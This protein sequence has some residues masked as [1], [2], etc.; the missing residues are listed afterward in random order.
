MTQHDQHNALEDRRA[1][2]RRTPSAHDLD[3]LSRQLGRPVRDVVEIGA[4]CVCGNPLVATTAPRLSNGIPFPTTYY[5]T[6]PVLTAAV[7][8][9]EAD[10]VMTAMSDRLTTDPELAGRYRAAHL[11]YLAAREA[12]GERAGTG[13]VPEIDGVSAGGMPTRVKCL[14]VLVGHALAAGPGVNPLGDEAIGGIAPWWTPDT[15]SCAGAWDTTGQAPDADLSRHTR[16]QGLSSEELDAKRAAR[17]RGTDTPTARQ[18]GETM[19][20]AAID[21]GTNS[22]RLLIADIRDGVLTDVVR[23]MRVVRLGEGVDA[24]GRL[25]EAALERTFAAAEEYAA[26]IAEHGNPPVRFVATSASRDAENRQDFVDGIRARLGVEPEV[27]SGDEEARLSFDGAVSVLATDAHETVLVV[28]LGGGSTEFVAGTADG[29]IGALSTDMGCVRFTERFLRD[30]PPTADQI[31]AMEAEV[32]HHIDRAAAA[33]PLDRVTKIV[34]VAGTVTTVTAH[35][36]DLPAYEPDR[37]HG[38]ELPIPTISAAATD[39]L[40][41][42]REARAALPYMHPGRVDVIGAGALIWKTILERVAV[43]TGGRVTTA[44]TSEHDILDGIALSVARQGS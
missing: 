19:R 17:R 11:A 37:I 20:T 41:R 18:Q 33:V 42:P 7:S 43:L 23:L 25:S 34:G 21:C 5:L 22:I 28:D 13:P 2:D 31:T 24:T 26:L 32:R 40:H 9:L 10:G 14:H 35:A 36:L 12:V 38:A 16:T 3:V 27:I 4:R 30:N 39:L 44:I 1:T 15:C 8:R 6:H 29:L